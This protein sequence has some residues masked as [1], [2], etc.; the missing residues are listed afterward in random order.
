MSGHRDTSFD[1]LI[2]ELPQWN[3]GGGIDIDDWIGCIGRFDHAIGYSRVFWPEFVLHDGCLLRAGFSHES[4]AGFMRQAGGNRR[5]VE[6]VMNHVHIEDLFMG[7]V[8]QGEDV[9]RDKIVY[10]GRALKDM[11]AAR[12]KRDFPT[13]DIVVSFPEADDEDLSSYEITV[14]QVE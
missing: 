5:S 8:N 4:F 12:L 1:R 14:F 13:L 10:L 6:A 2:P 9:T 3:N 7:R 11:W